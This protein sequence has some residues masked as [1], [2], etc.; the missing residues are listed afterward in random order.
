MQKVRKQGLVNDLWPNIRLIQASGLFISSYY[1][2]NSTLMRLIRKIYSWT[3]TVLIFTQY[4]FLCIF[5][6]TESYTADQRAAFTVTIFFFTHP[7]IKF[8][9]FSTGNEKFTRTLAAWNNANSH[10]LFTESNAR[11]RAS[12]VTRMRKLLMFAGV[13]TIFTTVSWTLITFVG[14]SVREVA[15]PESENGTMFI[16][17]PRL[18]LPSMYPFDVMDGTGYI[19]AFVYQVLFSLVS[20]D[21]KTLPCD[22]RSRPI[23]MKAGSICDNVLNKVC[24]NC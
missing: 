22:F 10:P 24:R 23:A 5:A 17:A 19:V 11:F 2:N 9:Y 14:D 13:V 3:V 16:E 6:A 20:A 21:L 1:E 18:M 15:D 4:I 12:G 7:L 8:V